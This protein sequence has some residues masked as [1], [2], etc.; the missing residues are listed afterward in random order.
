MSHTGRPSRL[1][2]S[3]L[4]CLQEEVLDIL[5]SEAA[6]LSMWLDLAKAY[7]ALG[8]EDAFIKVCQE[9]TR[10]EVTIEV[11]KFFGKKPTWV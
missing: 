10:D 6:P 2:R 4:L 8:N 11:E 7:L 5:A 9:G 1:P 3:Q